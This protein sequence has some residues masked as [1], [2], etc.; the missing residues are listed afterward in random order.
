[1]P[2]EEFQARRFLAHYAR[3]IGTRMKNFSAE[4]NGRV[5][6]RKRLPH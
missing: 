2:N 5:G 4:S 6:R 3:A 1:V